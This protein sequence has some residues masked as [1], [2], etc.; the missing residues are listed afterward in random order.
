MQPL[1]EGFG[2]SSMFTLTKA[3][4][5]CLSKALKGI[6]LSKAKHRAGIMVNEEGTEAAA[7]GELD[8]I[9]PKTGVLSPAI[10][11]F[12]IERPFIFAVVH[13]KPKSILFMGTVRNPLVT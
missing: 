12:S 9:D 3:D 13:T 6:P 1:R 10:K 11:K 8:G 4:F 7:A 5:G 2:L